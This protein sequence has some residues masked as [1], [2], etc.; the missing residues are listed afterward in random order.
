MCTSV[1]NTDMC[2]LLNNQQPL[3]PWLSRL[4]SLSL[5]LPRSLSPFS[6]SCLLSH[7]HTQRFTLSRDT[8]LLTW[9]FFSFTFSSLTKSTSVTNKRS[10]SPLT[11]KHI[12]SHFHCHTHA[13][14]AILNLL[15]SKQNSQMVTCDNFRDKHTHSHSC[16]WCVF[17]VTHTPH[18]LA[19]TSTPLSPTP[20]PFL[21]SVPKKNLCP[22]AMHL[23][24]TSRHI[25]EHEGFSKPST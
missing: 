9:L 3:S 1:L 19:P 10:S 18:I 22:H 24:K 5:P 15:I 2:L 25:K 6:H 8:H 21:Q 7:A 12:H 11:Q 20:T 23:Q 17:S 4:R 13:P 16:V 14:G